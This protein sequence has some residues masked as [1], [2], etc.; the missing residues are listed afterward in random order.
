MRRGK[1]TD[2]RTS[3]FFDEHIAGNAGNHK[4]SATEIVYVFKFMERTVDNAV[5]LARW[6]IGQA[7]L[8][9]LQRSFGGAAVHCSLLPL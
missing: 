3:V 6:R 4:A 7:S 1:P 8:S 2:R 5:Q 9:Y